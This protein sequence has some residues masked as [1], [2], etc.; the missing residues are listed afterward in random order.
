MAERNRQEAPT[1]TL[2]TIAAMKG[3]PVWALGV[4]QEITGHSYV[5][6]YAERHPTR[7]TLVAD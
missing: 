2:D 6:A 4:V 3:V 7:P 1:P 5:A